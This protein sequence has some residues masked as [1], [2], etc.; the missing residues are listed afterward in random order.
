MHWW[1]L[2][3]LLVVMFALN[4]S[5]P[6]FAEAVVFTPELLPIDPVAR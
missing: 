3:A 5:Q 1:A 4:V 6:L 2:L